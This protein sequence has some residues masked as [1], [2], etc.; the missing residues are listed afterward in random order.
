M[1]F[2][3]T[4]GRGMVAVSAAILALHVAQAGLAQ[5]FVPYL[6]GQQQ[7][8]GY[9]QYQPYAP[10]QAQQ[11]Y[12]PQYTAMA[13]QGSDTR[14]TQQPAESIDPG[15]VQSS[16]PMQ[17]Y[18]SVPA[19]SCNCQAAP[20]AAAGYGQPAPAPMSYESYPSSG[21]Y[22]SGACGAYNTFSGGGC[23]VGA[24]YGG[25]NTG[26]NTGCGVGG[27]QGYL[28]AGLRGCGCGCRWFGGFY[29]LYMERVGNPWKALAFSTLDT[30][31][32]GYYPTDNEVV[33]N[34]TDLDHDTFVG[35]E[36][37]FGSTLGQGGPCGCGPRF[38]W[39]VAY[40]GL[41]EE[42]Q[43]AV[44]TDT[45]ADGDRL[46]GM[47]PHTGAFYNGRPVRDYYDAGPPTANPAGDTI[48]L[49]QLTARN[50]FSMQNL[51][52]NLLHFPIAGGGYYSAAAGGGYGGGRGF[53]R[54]SGG[55][56]GGCA[57]GG[58]D[59][60]AGGSCGAGCGCRPRCS[61]SGVVGVRY[62]R[63]DEDFM[64]RADFDN[65]TAVTTGFISHAVDVDSHLVGAQFG[66]NGIYHCGC[67]GR[68]ALHCNT[69]VGVFGNHSEVWNRMDAPVAGGG[70]TLQNGDNFNL[71]Y[72][73]DQVAVLGEL[74]AGASYQ[75]SC[76]WRLFGGYRLLGIS[77]V[78]LAF[79]QISDQNISAAQ[80][81][82]VDFDGSIFI[83]GLQAGVEC[84]Y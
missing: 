67:A 69:A 70:V 57:T 39:E 27:G 59:S 14:A 44:V 28:D 65:E 1:R 81:S 53:G 7:N 9:A 4:K 72:E 77:G 12:P 42:D 38:G 23:G 61:I 25:C 41:I 32:A 26:C 37:R 48:R 15:P 5:Q 75:Y 20:A 24:P 49:R 66:C 78:A 43:T 54:R 63:F 74:R 82:Y 30:N 2:S 83:H 56:A 3:W 52:V 8:S 84:T 13:Y 34:L 40:W 80:T 10:Q 68:W 6:G 79:D 64:Y 18:S 51:E 16:A 55:G 46:Y 58:C 29:G 73:D 76:N 33:L 17:S 22:G 62:V 71:R 19:A 50:S 47:M 60:C 35:A 11:Q 31:P 21:A 45:A 36:V